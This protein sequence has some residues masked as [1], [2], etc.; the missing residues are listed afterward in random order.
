MVRIITAGF[1]RY[2]QETVLAAYEAERANRA[3]EQSIRY[4]NG[5]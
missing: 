1:R 5:A 2:L 4:A 3:A